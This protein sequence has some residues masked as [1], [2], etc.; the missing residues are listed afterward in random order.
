MEVAAVQALRQARDRAAERESVG[1]AYRGVA[2][3]F[4]AHGWAAAAAPRCSG[5]RRD[6]VCLPRTRVF[7]APISEGGI[8][9]SAISMAAYGLRQV[10]EVQFADYFYPLRL[11]R[12]R[13]G[14]GG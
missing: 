1:A 2:L 8:V 3:M 7:D 5:R 4:G 14:G 11:D 12:L 9:G 13:G 10:V 6:R